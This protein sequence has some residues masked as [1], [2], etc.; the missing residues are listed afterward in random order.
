MYK[1]HNYTIFERAYTEGYICARKFFY[2]DGNE[3]EHHR[4]ETGDVP[5]K[6]YDG[7]EKLRSVR[8]TSN[9]KE[10][11]VR[12]YCCLCDDLLDSTYERIQFLSKQI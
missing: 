5:F 4:E 1:E 2:I 10:L 9:R 6:T 3:I 8:T 12:N 11:F 7:T